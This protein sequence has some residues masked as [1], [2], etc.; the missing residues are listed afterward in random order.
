MKEEG[1]QRLTEVLT[2]L[3]VRGNKASKSKFTAG[4][5]HCDRTARG[6]IELAYRCLDY[7]PIVANLMQRLNTETR[8]NFRPCVIPTGGWLSVGGEKN[9]KRGKSLEFRLA[10][11]GPAG[12][13]KPRYVTVRLPKTHRKFVVKLARV[14]K[15]YNTVSADTAR[16]IVLLFSY[17]LLYVYTDV[18]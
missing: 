11:S 12:F 8:R 7:S 3:F 14:Q 6:L 4:L 13:A 1:I 9:V 15:K 18:E 5:P 10:E 17:L 2:V 16:V